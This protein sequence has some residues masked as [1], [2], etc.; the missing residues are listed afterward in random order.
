[1]TLANDAAFRARVFE[2]PQAA[3]QRY[4]EVLSWSLLTRGMTYGGEM[5][6]LIGA[7][8]IWKP[9][10]LPSMPISI[11]TAPPS[12]NRPPPYADGMDASNRLSY[13]YRG[14]D[15]MHP[16]NVGLREAMRT[17]AP[18]IYFFGVA[19]GEYLTTWPVFIVEDDPPGLTFKVSIDDRMISSASRDAAID[20]FW[21]FARTSRSKSARTSWPRSTGPCF[22][23][24]C[25]R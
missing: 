2:W 21:E 12:P 25:R 6:P 11:A 23:T 9:R 19:K 4:G 18:L 5:V 22:T 13:R 14:Q 20:T 3:T 7:K 24:A 16:D 17:R 1:M 8:G 15:P 10:I